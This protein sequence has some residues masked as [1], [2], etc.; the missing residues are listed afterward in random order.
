[1]RPHV[2]DDQLRP[3]DV[4]GPDATWD[5]ISVFGHGYH[6]YKVA[7]SL[8]RVAALTVEAHDAWIADGTLPDSLPRLR[9]ALFHTVRATHGGVPSADTEAWARALV[10]GIRRERF[11]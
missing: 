2:P 9:L 1:M 10:A 4:P 3:S 7:G 11:G 5:E 6:A 8:Q